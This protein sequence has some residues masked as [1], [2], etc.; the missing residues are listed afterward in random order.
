MVWL[1]LFK[2][3]WGKMSIQHPFLHTLK[4]KLRSNN[5]PC[6][7]SLSMWFSRGIWKWGH[8]SVPANQHP[9]IPLST[10]IGS[11]IDDSSIQSI[12]RLLL[13]LL[14]KRYSLFCR[15]CS[16]VNLGLSEAILPHPRENLTKNE[17]NTKRKQNQKMELDQVLMT[18]I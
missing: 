7:Y 11:A 3:M 15:A 1:T 13:E 12:Q 16:A 5:L 18:F 17:A 6:T 2:M 4:G 14:G 9:P 8:D 10:V